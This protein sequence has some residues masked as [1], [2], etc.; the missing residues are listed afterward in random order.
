MKAMKRAAMVAALSLAFG[1]A[2]AADSLMSKDQVKA[3]KDRIEAEHKQAK[4]LCDG[5]SGNAK[6]VCKKEAEG[7]EKIAKADL[8]AREKGTPEARRKA[9][10]AKVNAE[11]EVAKEKCDDLSGNAKDVCQ[12]DA[13]AAEK[14]AKANLQVSLGTPGA[15][16][17][18][19]GNQTRAAVADAENAQ[20]K[21]DKERCE[22]LEGAAKDRCTADVKARYNKQ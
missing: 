9:A 4:S 17:D 1:G 5:M 14:S 15:A 12:K 11:Y 6:D 19:S 22:S 7:N 10:E 3:A 13:K 2:Y 16:A 21:A 8:E 20:Y 18:V